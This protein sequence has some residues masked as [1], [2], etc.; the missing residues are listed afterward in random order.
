[1]TIPERI[2]DLRHLM[3]KYHIDYYIVPTADYHQSEYVGE[4]FKLREWITGFNGSAGTAVIT[5]DT[6]GLWTD[7]RYF[8][9]ATEQ[10]KNSGVTLFKM[11]EPGVPSI[12]E[13]LKKSV[14]EGQTIAFDGRN[15]SME[16]GLIYENIA[17]ANTA[18]LTYDVDLINTIW[19]DRPELSKEAAFHLD[20]NYSGESTSSK[21]CRLR[22][23]MK[24][25]NANFHVLSSLDDI[26]WLLNIRGN[27]IEFSPMVLSYAIV[28]METVE[29]FIDETKL[30]QLI[31]DDL[32]KNKVYRHPYNNVY[33]FIKSIKNDSRLLI[34]PARLN[35]AL[36]KNISDKATIINQTNPTI[37][38]KAIKNEIELSNMKQ[39]QIKDGIAYTKYMYW[40]KHEIGKKKI[41]ELSAS[42]QLELFRKEQKGYIRQS[43]APIVA[44]GEHAALAHYSASEVSDVEIKQGA[45]LV[46]DTGGGYYEG[47][48]D[49]TRTFALGEVPDE[50][51][52]H[53]TITLRSHIQ[54]AQAVFLQGV[55]GTN[56]DV[57]ARMPFWQEHLNYN[58]GTGHGIGYLLNIHEG[59][60][61]IRWQLRENDSHELLEGMVLTNEPGIYIEGSHGVRLENEILVTKDTENEYGA[62]LKFET[63]SYVPFDIDAI[64]LDLL[65]PDEKTW[66]NNYH[67]LV[68]Q[69]IAPHLKTNELQWLKEITKKI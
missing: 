46:S 15:V 8:I 34:D 9:A 55:N 60:A 47:S 64:D 63:M 68:Y 61:G 50:L 40:L 28:T 4:H 53:Y 33:E 11:G 25:H 20:I 48:T 41:T 10:L 49:I 18:N 67:A 54:L 16:E 21:L 36:V 19:L 39:A 13:F 69:L 38:F 45:F 43:F 32:D 3:K 58:H 66:L 51:K 65:L 17:K 57:L 7:G 42:N 29:L 35:Y 30:N 12:E 1:M 24:E 52:K 44:Y 56:L 27:D 23:S 6:A 62:F 2:T 14:K 59:P 37:L 26:G 22:K 31:I 5:M